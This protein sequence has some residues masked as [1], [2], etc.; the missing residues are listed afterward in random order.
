MNVTAA[1]G[2]AGSHTLK[3]THPA[4]AAA[5]GLPPASQARSCHRDFALAL[6]SAWKTLALFCPSNVIFSVRLSLT[7]IKITPHSQNSESSFLSL[8]LVLFAFCPFDRALSAICCAVM[9]CFTDLFACLHQP[10][11][12][13]H[14]AGPF[15]PLTAVSPPSIVPG[16]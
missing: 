8:H 5:L 1:L 11:C 14:G 16:T 2:G 13:L 10:D 4:R 6:P 3:T 7:Q 15:H 12:Q 9:F